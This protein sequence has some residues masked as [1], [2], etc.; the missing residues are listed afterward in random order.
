MGVEGEG[1]PGVLVA[2]EPAEVGPVRGW[3]MDHPDGIVVAVDGAGR[4]KGR[5]GAWS[6]WGV[7]SRCGREVR[8][9]DG[10]DDSP[11]RTGRRDHDG[12][13]ETADE[14]LQARQGGSRRPGASAR[15]PGDRAEQDLQPGR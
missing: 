5:D 10:R 3:S 13:D 8:R 1:V 12:P 9:E 14:W 4:D 6:A 2:C 11:D 7:G 15:R